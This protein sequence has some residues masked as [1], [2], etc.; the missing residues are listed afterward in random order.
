VNGEKISVAA[1]GG[2]MP[3]VYDLVTTTP[4]GGS[5]DPLSGDYSVP[6]AGATE[7]TETI[8]AIDTAGCLGT[9][10]VKISTDTVA[11][12]TTGSG[13]PFVVIN[14]PVGS[15][16]TIDDGVGTVTSGGVYSSAEDGIGIVK[17]SKGDEWAKVVIKVKNGICTV[18]EP[19][20]VQDV[21]MDG[22]V[23]VNDLTPVIDWILSH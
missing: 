10:T 16:Y 8:R 18:I 7:V 19:T 13:T 4:T 14:G 22:T 3:Y 12:T 5:I 2:V 1:T 9:T 20:P 15:T 17:V 6:K 23:D 11:V 21:N